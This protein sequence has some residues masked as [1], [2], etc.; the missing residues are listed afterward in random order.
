[1]TFS[2]ASR[3][4]RP[5]CATLER[6][7]LQDAVTHPSAHLSPRPSQKNLYVAADSSHCQHMSFGDGMMP[8]KEDFQVT[9]GRRQH[10]CRQHR[11]RQ[12]FSQASPSWLLPPFPNLP[13]AERAG[14]GT[15]AFDQ[16]RPL[17][18]ALLTPHSSSNS[19]HHAPAHPGPPSPV[20]PP[21][22]HCTS[23]YVSTRCKVKTAAGMGKVQRY[24]AT[25]SRVGAPGRQS[26]ASFS[27]A[28]ETSAISRGVSNV[29]AY[30]QK[31]KKSPSVRPVHMGALTIAAPVL[32]CAAP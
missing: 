16:P 17:G 30:D 22:P 7:A 19:R 23:T 21:V 24:S 25:I 27:G 4:T 5:R 20:Q 26:L 15:L 32:F 1:M 8:S 31:K 18:A 12:P 11:R 3:S 28:L 10:R 29:C 6:G 9:H 2:R 14:A 13:F